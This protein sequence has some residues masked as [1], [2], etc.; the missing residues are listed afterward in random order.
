MTVAED[1]EILLS[2]IDEVDNITLMKQNEPNTP[3]TF[4][5]N[6]TWSAKDYKHELYLMIGKKL[7][8]LK[9]NGASI[10]ID[11]VNIQ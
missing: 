4:E 9:K 10:T 8:E 11:A 3:V 6:E 5:D 1:I 7:S 2:T